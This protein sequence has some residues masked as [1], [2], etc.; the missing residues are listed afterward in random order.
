M[1]TTL[2]FMVKGTPG[3]VPTPNTLALGPEIIQFEVKSL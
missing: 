3:A 1:L 2:I